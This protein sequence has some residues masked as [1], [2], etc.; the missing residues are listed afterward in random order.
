MKVGILILILCLLAGC[1]ARNTKTEQASN[2]GPSLYGLIFG[3]TKDNSG[4][5]SSVRLARVEDAMAKKEIQYNLREDLLLQAK[6]KLTQKWNTTT[7][8]REPGIEFFVICLYSNI[9]PDVV[10]CG[11]E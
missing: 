5:V 11:E 2:K 1:Q 3:I 4:N 8:N 6:D 7:S 9:D 10:K